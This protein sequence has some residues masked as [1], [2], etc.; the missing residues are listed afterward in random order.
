MVLLNFDFIWDGTPPA[1][2][3]LAPLIS[4]MKGFPAKIPNTELPG[5]FVD[6]LDWTGLIKIST[7]LI[8][9]IITKTGLFIKI[10]NG[11]TSQIKTRKNWIIIFYFI[12]KESFKPLHLNCEIKHNVK[13]TGLF[14]WFEIKWLK[15]SINEW[16]VVCG[17]LFHKLQSSRLNCVL[18]IRSVTE[19]CLGRAARGPGIEKEK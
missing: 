4:P 5:L 15:R 14:Y 9:I 17:D 19:I 1:L 16:I 13:C 3:R 10:C 8:I 6:W 12:S 2:F 7:G 11:Y 18:Y